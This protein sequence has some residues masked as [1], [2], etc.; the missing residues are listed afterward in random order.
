MLTDKLNIESSPED[1]FRAIL[2][3]SPFSIQIMSPDGRIV[4]VNRAWEEL[5]GTTLEQIEGYNIFEDEQL[6][7]KGIMPYI[8]RAFAGEAVEIPPV[9]YDPNA[10]MPN[11]TSHAEP[12]RWTKSV[13]YPIKDA[14]GQV[15]EVVLVHEDITA[16]VVAEESVKA[17]E[18][19]YRSLLENANDI[20]YSH[21]LQGN[22]L[23][24][25][26]AGEVATG[27]TRAEI[28]GGLNIA[29][30][31]APEH[32]ERAK[33]MMERKLHDPTP[34]V[35][36]VDIIA[37]DKRRLTL[38]VS[39]RIS[40]R[41]GRPVAVEGVAR[42]VTERK[43]V[44]RER[45]L[46]TEQVENQRRHLQAM[47]SSVPGVVWEAWGEP[48]A[49]SQRIDFVSDYVEKMLGYSVEEW[50]STPN[51]WLTIVHEEDRE[52]ARREAAAIYAGGKGGTSSFRWVA[53]DGRVVWVE[54]QSVVICDEQGRAI[55][56]R[57]VT[58]DITERKQKEAAERFLFEASTTL[59]SSLDYETTL[60]TVARLA[61]PYFADWCSVDVVNE[62]GTLNR[63]A[64]AHVE[65]EKIAWAQELYKR[66]P[67]DPADL[68]GVYNV[69]RTGQSEFYSEITDDMLVQGARDA[70]HLDVLRQVG[71]RSVMLIPLKARGRT[72]GIMTFINTGS[73]R[74][75][76]A[77]DLALA[78]D[79][80][81]RAALAFDNATLYRAEQQ[82]RKAAERTSDRL[83]RLQAVA[84]ALSQA[85]TPRQVAT[86]VIEQGLN[87]LGAQAGSVV[88]LSDSGRE[89][90]IVGTLGFPPE[91]EKKWERFP[92]NAIVPIADAF[93]NK[94]PIII[95]SL[96]ERVDY[97]SALGPLASVTGT[98]ALITF[99][100]IVE[101]RNIGAMGLSFAAEQHFS[102]D[103]H[104]FMIALA[105]Q[106]AQALE[107]AR[108]YETEQRLRTEA[109]AANRIKDEFLATVSHELRTPL[110]AIVGWA[111]ML[112]NNTF[113]AE[114]TA[115]AL[116]SIERNA[117]AQTQI[118]EDLLD[119]S[120]IITGKLHLDARASELNAPIE[121]ALEVI[122]PAA[123]TKG[124]TIHTELEQGAG[125]VWCDPARIQQVM[126]NLLFNAVKFTPEGGAIDLHLRRVGTHV[127]V[128]V[129]DTGQG[130]A[131]EFLPFV[132]ERFRQ[133][134]GT[135]TRRHGGLGL[136]LAIVRH[137]VEMHGG[138]VRVESAGL[139]QGATF[140]VE[141]PLITERAVKM[142]KVPVVHSLSDSVPLDCAPNLDE[143]RILIVDDE[144]DARVLLRTII[145]RCGARVLTVGSVADAL[146]ALKQ[147]QPD[148]LISDI[149]M[150]DEDGYSLIRKVRNLKREEGGNIP[151]I[152]LTAYARDEDRM[153]AL[154]AGY[155]MH[156]AKP[157]NPA[158]LVA[159]VGG[160][161]GIRARK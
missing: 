137:L 150:P 42:D 25:N 37:K 141:L 59:A 21:D 112:R 70:E 47:V 94:A 7:E 46:L 134:D 93:R 17:S 39:T 124:I 88:A 38:E 69:L 89:L 54:A 96:A 55:G 116:E 108:L 98:Q 151:A 56:M 5:W 86:A 122:R 45:A 73:S 159:L 135:I 48:E 97:Y 140:T 33:R 40:F 100:L 131:P 136:G 117:K 126:W 115:R 113:D 2:E 148:I 161:A 99:P 20:I 91:V 102:E 92:V 79:L 146:E 23:S 156:L 12:Q 114:A 72:L 26:R 154:L 28:L 118:I 142:D 11:V 84:A 81:Y 119:V 90:E 71:F 155:Q 34:T 107:R 125:T 138:T 103:D 32:L 60:A 30:V 80:A 158:E 147:F 66:Y 110:T 152:A 95:E 49:G 36:E 9:L 101:G 78:E 15:R 31:V 44:E 76:T 129:S 65:P 67:P 64:V 87:S 133:A 51:F 4:R 6:V 68:R 22:Y 1:R 157:V 123:L 3:Q 53:R 14:A 50:L 128:S 149:G 62:D 105:Q 74:R 111:S 132:F 8:R 58:M 41:D 52:R 29:Q 145:E 83:T 75:H 153:R 130:I 13:A 82:T 43:R 106:C 18:E 144:P 127:Q 77:E 85:L 24:I 27:Y 143:V 139:D 121:L 57:G 61:V 19:R 16:R 120:R 109:E 104:A 10:T 63:L 160:L 35:Y